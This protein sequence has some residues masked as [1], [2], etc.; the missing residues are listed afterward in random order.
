[1][2]PRCPYYK[3]TDETVYALRR[4]GLRNQEGTPQWECGMFGGKRTGWYGTAQ[5]RLKTD[6]E[7]VRQA[8]H[9][10]MKGM[11]A[12]E[13]SEILEVPPRTIQRWLDRAGAH[14]Q[15]LHQSLLKGLCLKYIQLDELATKVRNRSKQVWVWT[16]MDVTTRLW[17]AWVVRECSQKEANGLLPQIYRRVR[18]DIPPPLSPAMA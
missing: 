18:H 17:V 2:N 4:N 9:M 6:S 5:Y 15:G 10:Q 3:V 13:I 14:S 11:C 12:A 1:M 16:G 7:K 8:I